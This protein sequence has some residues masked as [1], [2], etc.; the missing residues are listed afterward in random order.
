MIDTI[1]VEET[2]REHPRTREI[3]S[4][5]SEKRVIEVGRY[6]ELFNAGAQNFRIQ[7]KNPA[8]ILAKKR[9]S[10]VLSAPQEYRIG[11]GRNYYFSHM[12]NCLYDCRYCFLQGMY[13]S[14]HYVLFVDYEGFLGAIDQVIA[15]SDETAWFCSGYDCDSLALEPVTRFVENFVPAFSGRPSAELELRTKST[16]I[17]S[18]LQQ[19]PIPNVV[20][21]FSFTPAMIAQQLE[22]RAPGVEKRL[23]A[24]AKLQQAGWRIGLR[25]DPLIYHPDFKAMYSGLYEQVFSRLDANAIHSVSLGVFR[26]PKGYFKTLHR[27]YPD[28]HL[29]A[30]PLEQNDGMISYRQDLEMEMKDYCHGAL[31][32]HISPEI[33]FPCHEELHCDA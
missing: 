16:Q 22:H 11:E 21:A 4:R 14:A 23:D 33:Y 18:L 13:R 17:R 20:V 3:L 25:F 2:I 30:A 26:L 15:E 28:E 9:Q 6:T 32:T 31:L 5:Y 10:Y 12:L 27:L 8:L 19:A 7:K 1:Y 29:F 24:A